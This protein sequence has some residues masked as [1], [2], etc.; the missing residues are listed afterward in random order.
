MLKNEE[1]SSFS[2]IFICLVLKHVPIIYVPIST[3]RVS[4]KAITVSKIPYGTE[5]HL[6]LEHVSDRW[7]SPKNP[8]MAILRLIITFCQTEQS[9]RQ[10]KKL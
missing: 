2:Y 9:V 3:F 7:Q 8:C 5:A 10:N 6:L 4:Y 1:F